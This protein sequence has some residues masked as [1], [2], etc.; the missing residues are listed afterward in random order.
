MT[1]LKQYSQR[2][3]TNNKQFSSNQ[4]VFEVIESKKKERKIIQIFK[5]GL[6]KIETIG[7]LRT[8]N[9][10]TK[11]DHDNVMSIKDSLLENNY[12]FLEFEYID[13]DLQK[14]LKTKSQGLT[15]NHIKYIFYQIV[16][17]VAYMHSKGVEHLNLRP[18]NILLTNECDVK[19]G[20]LDKASPTFLSKPN[21][22]KSV[23]QD[24]FTAPETILNNGDNAHCLFKADIWAIG[25]IFFELLEKKSIL[26]YQR[27]YLEM[28]KWVFK[29]LGKPSKS[30]IQ[31][32]NN[33]SARSWVSGNFNYPKKMPSNY[34]SSENQN[35]DVANLLDSMLKF[36]P[37]DRPSAEAL[38]KHP[39]F[40]ELFDKRDLNFN[41]ESLSPK[42]FIG[43]NSQ[44]QDFRV[45]KNA[46]KQ[47]IRT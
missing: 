37:S 25:C 45:I 9:L 18:K 17:G 39:Y 31:F 21:S 46:L 30:E 28:L 14:I 44:I 3:F 13:Y 4:T 23:Y 43:C 22:L 34:L 32:I 20:G 15:G 6:N 47:V 5:M 41:Q 16:L 33:K 42:D 38:L 8:I 35:N 1:S 29:L 27:Q 19:I 7:F 10:L 24:Y 26:N 11:L 12:A 40:S 36:S 2:F